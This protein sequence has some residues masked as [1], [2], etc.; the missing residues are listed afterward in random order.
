[1]A[2]HLLWPFGTLVDCRSVG[3]GSHVSRDSRDPR[4]KLGVS[5]PYLTLRSAAMGDRNEVLAARFAK[6]C[7]LQNTERRSAG[8]KS[9]C[10]IERRISFTLKGKVA[11]NHFDNSIICFHKLFRCRLVFWRVASSFT[12]M[13]VAM[14]QRA[15]VSC[16][17]STATQIACPVPSSDLLD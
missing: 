10:K 7:D 9:L 11:T 4:G 15:A 13:K 17:A 16:S 8:S 2:S 14:P 1:M 12:L 3:C 5:L 6:E